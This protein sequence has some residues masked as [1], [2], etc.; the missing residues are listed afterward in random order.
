V[1]ETVEA[2][3]DSFSDHLPSWDQLGIQ[4]MQDVLEVF[5]LS[6]F[7]RIEQLQELLDEGV[8]DEYL[9]SLDICSFIDD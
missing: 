3:G 4:S 5:P 2:V 1:D 8:R 6:W 9:Q 7:L